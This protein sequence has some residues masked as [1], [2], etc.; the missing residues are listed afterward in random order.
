MLYYC[1]TPQGNFGDDLNP[2]LWPRLAP[3]VCDPQG[4]ALFVGIGTILSHKVPREPLEIVFGSGWGGGPLPKIDGKWT[5]YCVRGPITA[6]TLGLDPALALHLFH[7]KSA[8]IEA[9]NS[10]CRPDDAAAL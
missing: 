7:Q 10:G 4:P 8:S 9:D 3:E 6:A 1:K 5:I 2:S